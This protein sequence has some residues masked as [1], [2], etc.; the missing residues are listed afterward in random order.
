MATKADG[1]PGDDD[2]FEFNFPDEEP[3][4]SVPKMLE[5]LKQAVE[6]MAEINAAEFK[7]NLPD[8][9]PLRTENTR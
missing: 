4:E 1:E 7:R 6:G 3:E 9:E 8:E 5:R 2:G